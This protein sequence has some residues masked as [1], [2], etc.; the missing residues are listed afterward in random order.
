M[1]YR[2]ERFVA[3]IESP[4]VA[5]IEDKQM[6]F[7]DGKAL[8]ETTFSK[9]FCIESLAARGSK[10]FVKLVENDRLNDMNWTGEEQADFF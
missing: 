4:V 7:A 5:V 3:K 9:L 10:V 1:T 2:V 8:A 6:E